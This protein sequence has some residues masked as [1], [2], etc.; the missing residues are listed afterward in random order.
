MAVLSWGKPTIKID[1][2]SIDTPKEGTTKLTVQTGDKVEARLEGGG[3]KDVR[4]KEGTATLEFD[5]YVG[6]D[7]TDPFEGKITNGVLA[8]D[9]KVTVVPEDATCKGVQI[10]RASVNRTIS[11]DA[12]EGIMYHYSIDALTP[13][14]GTEKV[15]I[16]KGGASS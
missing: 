16:T 7:D 5:L 4:Y 8:G 12:E 11:Y 3:V 14:D 1:T 13:T 10:D 15:K 9:H 6:K 2:T